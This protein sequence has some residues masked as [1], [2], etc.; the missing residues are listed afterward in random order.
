MLPV[1][2]HDASLTQLKQ[3]AA[4]NSLGDEDIVNGLFASARELTSRCIAAVAAGDVTGAQVRGCRCFP[5]GCCAASA[6]M[7]CHSVGV[8]G[9]V[10]ALMLPLVQQ[11]L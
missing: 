7:P 2:K 9:G 8:W 5:L 10:C 11:R 6:S 3:R 4:A 1:Q